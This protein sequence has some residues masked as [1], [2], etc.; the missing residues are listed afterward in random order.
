MEKFSHILLVCLILIAACQ[1]KQDPNSRIKL[2]D[3]VEEIENSMISI[4]DFINNN[5]QVQVNLLDYTVVDSTI[6][7]F[8][9]GE[10]KFIC[11][12]DSVILEGKIDNISTNG[13]KSLFRSIN[14]LKRNGIE[15]GFY[16]SDVG[17]IM[18]PY[19]TINE[20]FEFYTDYYIVLNSEKLDKVKL[21][22]FYNVVDRKSNLILVY[23]KGSD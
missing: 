16:S 3:S 18:Y 10:L 7:S 6:I 20:E 2:I 12:N 21:N 4:N 22:R 13:L 5:K 11:L 8:S 23:F 19:K 17:A 9:D 14:V 1:N 15:G